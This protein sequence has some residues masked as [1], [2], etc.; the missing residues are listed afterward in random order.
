MYDITGTK[1]LVVTCNVYVKE[2]LASD[3]WTLAVSRKVTV[4]GEAVE[5]E[6]GSAGAPSGF[7][8]VELVK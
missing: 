2:N 4:G 8:K 7:Y 1:T 3:A 6:A 5:I